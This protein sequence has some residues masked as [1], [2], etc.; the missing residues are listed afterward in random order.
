MLATISCMNFF[1]NFSY[2]MTC[3]TPERCLIKPSSK[4]SWHVANLLEI[5]LPPWPSQANNNNIVST[6]AYISL[7]HY[8][9]KKGREYIAIPP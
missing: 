8:L 7:Y 5:Q 6:S 4:D 1:K 2:L 9:H 3:Y